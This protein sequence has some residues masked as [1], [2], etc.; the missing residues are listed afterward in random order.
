MMIDRCGKMFCLAGFGGN[1]PEIIKTTQEADVVLV[2]DGCP[3]D[4]VKKAL[5]RAVIIKF[6]HFEVTKRVTRLLIE[7]QFARSPNIEK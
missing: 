4:C 3:V 7:I 2:I 1:V 6:M 5:D